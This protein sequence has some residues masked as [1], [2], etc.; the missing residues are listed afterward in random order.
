MWMKLDLKKG[1]ILVT[2]LLNIRAF[3]RGSNDRTENSP[4]LNDPNSHLTPM[5]RGIKQKK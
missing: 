2:L 1:K 3:F 4:V 5:L